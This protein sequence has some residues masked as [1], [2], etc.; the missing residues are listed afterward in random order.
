MYCLGDFVDDYA[1]DEIERNDRS[2]IFLLEIAGKQ[3][4]RLLLYPTII[5]EFQ[6]QLATGSEREAI[7]AKIQQLCQ[8]LHTTATWNVQE[9]ALELRNSAEE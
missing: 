7:V 8:E 6:A 5:Q 9:N 3:I 4:T 1:V 2:C